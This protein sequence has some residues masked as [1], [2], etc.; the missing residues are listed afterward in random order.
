MTTLKELGEMKDFSNSRLS[1]DEG[2]YYEDCIVVVRE[3]DL[4]LE[5]NKRLVEMKLSQSDMS[6]AIFARACD[7]E[8]RTERI[9][10]TQVATGNSPRSYTA[11]GDEDEKKSNQ[12]SRQWLKD[13]KNGKRVLRKFSMRSSNRSTIFALVDGTIPCPPNSDFAIRVQAGHTACSPSYVTV[14]FRRR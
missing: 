5:N 10:G 13:Y 14:S 9:T 3:H 2:A 1:Q 12:L 8:A 7:S 11:N 6:N 4:Y